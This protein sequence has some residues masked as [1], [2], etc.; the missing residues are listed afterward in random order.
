MIEKIRILPKIPTVDGVSVRIESLFNAYGHTIL[1]LYAQKQNGDITALM[2]VLGSGCTLIGTDN[3]DYS[4]I[5]SFLS[6]LGVE[7]FCSLEVAKNLKVSDCE[8]VFLLEYIGIEQPSQEENSVKI[9]EV[10]E[11]L[12]NG[13]DGDIELPG[14]Q[15]W[16]ADYCIRKNHSS[17]EHFAIDGAVAVAGF[18]TE[19]EALITGVAVQ[20]S[21]RAKGKGKSA[22][23]GLVNKLR[24]EN[25]NKR[26]FVCAKHNKAEFYKKIGFNVL[27]QVLVAKI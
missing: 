16:Y 7:V 26:V 3:A 6:F 20:K 11:L 5:R 13:E 18:V 1:E 4:E 2:S 25:S 21:Q 10:Y 15:E 19:K 22:V 12:K 17:A 8:T 27:G 23:I 14:F 24:A 9:S